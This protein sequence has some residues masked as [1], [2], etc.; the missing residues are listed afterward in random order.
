[1]GM[2][3]IDGDPKVRETMEHLIAVTYD[4]SSCPSDLLYPH[5][6]NLMEAGQR[7]SVLLDRIGTG[8]ATTFD[9]DSYG[10]SDEQAD[11]PADV[12]MEED[13]SGEGGNAWEPVTQIDAIRTPDGDFLPHIRDAIDEVEHSTMS[14]D[15][16][17]ESWRWFNLFRLRIVHGLIRERGGARQLSKLMGVAIRTVRGWRPKLIDNPDWVPWCPDVAYRERARRIS[18]E[19]IDIARFRVFWDYIEP[20]RAF[21]ARDLIPVFRE[22][23]ECTHGP[24]EPW[25]GISL[26]TIQRFLRDSRLSW[27]RFHLKR[28]QIVPDGVVDTFLAK[29]RSLIASVDGDDIVNADETCWVLNAMTHYTWAER[30]AEGVQVM[31]DANAK[32][33]Y[34]VTAAVTFSG[35]KLPL[36]IIVQGKTRASLRLLTDVREH[37][38]DFSPNGWQT[39]VTF[40]RFLEWLR[41]L[42]QHRHGRT[43]HLVLDCFSVH[44]ADDAL[45]AADELDIKLHFVPAGLT[46]QMQ[47]LDRYVFGSLKAIY[48][49]IYREGLARGAFTK[50]GKKNFLALLIASWGQV[51][52]GAIVKGW[53]IFLE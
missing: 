30:G 7:I 19:M 34:T 12:T 37:S 33:S 4:L 51:P 43:L 35:K 24:H 39:L 32:Q 14:R 31:T 13:Q 2:P 52:S 47:P 1:M 15:R 26:S 22:A 50:V 27:R 9:M 48:H 44:R 6:D 21:V 40:L 8:D 5:R 18:T 20:K 3:Y 11:A 23:W 45:A 41:N 25:S 16:R 38:A 10:Q 46:D 49:R 17:T 42:P 28:R 53:S 29:M 36:Q